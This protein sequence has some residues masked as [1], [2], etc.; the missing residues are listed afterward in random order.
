MTD[1]I[2][3]VRDW[4]GH[5]GNCSDCINLSLKRTGG[6]P[7]THACVND[8][9]AR[10]IARFCNWKSALANADIAQAHFEVRAIA[11]KYGH[12]VLSAPLPNGAKETVRWNGARRLP[13][14]HVMRLH[15]DLQFGRAMHEQEVDL[16]RIGGGRVRYDW[17]RTIACR[18]RTPSCGSIAQQLSPESPTALRRDLDRGVNHEVATRIA[19]VELAGFTDSAVQELPARGRPAC[20]SARK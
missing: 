19:A 9:Y 14:Y 16:H 3:E 11:D 15:N 1:N 7:L 12:L 4:H 17:V 10:R 6:W 18:T 5:G 13:K 20:K 8:H 2:D